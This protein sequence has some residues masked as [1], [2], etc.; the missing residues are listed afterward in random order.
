MI[1]NVT[2][3]TEK[4]ATDEISRKRVYTPNMIYVA[5]FIGGPFAG[6]YL[7]AE[8]F[9]VFGRRR[10]AGITWIATFIFITLFALEYSFMEKIPNFLI[11]V[12]YSTI[13]MFL[14]KCYQGEQ[15]RECLETGGL[16]WSIWKVAL[17]IIVSLIVTI[18]LF[19]LALINT[20]PPML[21][22][23]SYMNK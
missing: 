18:L 14:A 19:L 10:F 16:K 22:E 4:N 7:M 1:E 17:V 23:Y 12:T 9:S 15:I 6:A 20:W 2:C 3:A 11:P 8:N 13:Y 5:A 21:G